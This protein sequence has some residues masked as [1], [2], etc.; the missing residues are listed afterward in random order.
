MNAQI[1]E[2]YLAAKRALF[3]AYYGARL[4]PEQVDAVL[5]VKGPLLILAGAGSGKTTVLV[6]RI[7][8][9]IKY[10][11]AYESEAVPEGVSEEELRALEAARNLPREEIEQILPS[12]ITAPCPPW[13]ID[14]KSVV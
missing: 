4:N 9:I 3:E 11:T 6:N 8:H 12:F 10:G 13:A 5:T 7:C 1:K 14:R 2:R